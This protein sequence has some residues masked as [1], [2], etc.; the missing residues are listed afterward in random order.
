M[1]DELE[2]MP[3]DDD[4]DVFSYDAHNDSGYAEPQHA[5]P[6]A[7]S[8]DL[9]FTSS[10]SL[11][12][13]SIPSYGTASA[14][15][16]CSVP[17]ATTSDPPLGR[18]DL[19]SRDPL[20]GAEGPNDRGV[21]EH[22]HQNASLSSGWLH[23]AGA[24]SALD[25]SPRSLRFLGRRTPGVYE[26]SRQPQFISDFGSPQ[27]GRLSPL[28][29]SESSI[30]EETLADAVH[31]RLFEDTDPLLA[32]RTRL[33]LDYPSGADP[34]PDIP[35]AVDKSGSAAYHTS[36]DCTTQLTS[37]SSGISPSRQEEVLLSATKCLLS[38]S[39]ESSPA[40]PTTILK[41]EPAEPT[42]RSMP[43]FALDSPGSIPSSL[44]R[45]IR[46]II[47]SVELQSPQ[48][49]DSPLL[50]ADTAPADGACQS[51]ATAP[52]AAETTTHAGSS[53]GLDIL[54][55][56][57]IPPSAN[58]RP[59]EVPIPGRNMPKNESEACLPKRTPEET[60]AGPPLFADDG[61]D[62]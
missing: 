28:Q 23:S 45:Y 11:P 20:V 14:D 19:G 3:F 34:P 22:F 31:G 50:V 35:V 9:F 6:E 18:F 37:P 5:Q 59:D 33:G 8:D 58:G 10:G 41:S 42:N 44:D 1:D 61:S 15:R 26:E 2:A 53:L 21:Y 29:R 46:S 60:I 16:S 27:N 17:Y 25:Y 40:V 24:P 12:G 57:S 30:V 48:D 39:P 13:S 55:T 51:T 54:L 36:T 47:E 38:V 62:D 4:G 56:D 43:P 32:I 7:L 49:F 52:A